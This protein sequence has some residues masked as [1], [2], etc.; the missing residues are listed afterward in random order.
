M[1]E[2]NDTNCKVGT[3]IPW[4]VILA[5]ALMSIEDVFMTIYYM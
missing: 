5:R 3:L 1:L 2:I 4:T